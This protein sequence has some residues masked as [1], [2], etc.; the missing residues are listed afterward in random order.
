MDTNGIFQKYEFLL[1][2]TIDGS[3]E[4]VGEDTAGGG[5]FPEKILRVKPL[6]VKENTGED[7]VGKE[8]PREGTVDKETAGENEIIDRHGR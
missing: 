2:Q 4:N 3:S 7:T 8:T 1:V 5:I 6:P